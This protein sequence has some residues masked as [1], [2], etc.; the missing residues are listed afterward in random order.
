MCSRARI[1]VRPYSLP[2]KPGTYCSGRSSTDLIAPSAIARPI[3]RPVI[4][5]TIDCETKRSRSVRA[6]WYCSTRIV[7]SR[8]ISNPVTGWSARWSAISA[9]ASNVP[10]L[11]AQGVAA[12]LT[13]RVL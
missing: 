3:S 6:Y 7:S 2:F 12:R 10:R 13:V 5:F 1:G 9:C 4:D 11:N 8:A